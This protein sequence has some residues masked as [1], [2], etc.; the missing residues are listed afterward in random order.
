MKTQAQPKP[1]IYAEWKCPRTGKPMH[2]E[3]IGSEHPH[4][5]RLLCLNQRGIV[6]YVPREEVTA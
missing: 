2:G 5:R 6:Q 1:R 4:H 3:V